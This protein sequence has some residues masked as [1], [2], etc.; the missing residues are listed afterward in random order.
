VAE[1]L[2]RTTENASEK[3]CAAW[4]MSVIVGGLLARPEFGLAEPCR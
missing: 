4:P 3:K 1:A 2:N